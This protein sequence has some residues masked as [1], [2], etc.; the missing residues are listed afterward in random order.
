[1]A[2]VVGVE[3]VDV[4]AD[5]RH[6]A[7]HVGRPVA[8]AALA[9][10][11]HRVV[12]HARG[13]VGV[14]AA[15]RWEARPRAD[16]C[17]AGSCGAGCGRAGLPGCGLLRAP[18]RGLG[19]PPPG[20]PR[21]RETA[22]CRVPVAQPGCGATCAAARPGTS[23]AGAG[24]MSTGDHAAAAGTSRGRRR[25]P[26][27]RRDRLGAGAATA[28]GTVAEAASGAPHAASR[29]TAG[30]TVSSRRITLRHRRAELRCCTIWRGSSKL[31]TQHLRHA[32]GNAA[33]R[34]SGHVEP[35]RTTGGDR[36]LPARRSG[37]GVGHRRPMDP[38]AAQA[39]H[40]GAHGRGRRQAGRAR[41]RPGAGIPAPAVAPGA[42][43]GRSATPTSSSPTT[44]AR[45]R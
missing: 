40:A 32:S 3:A 8:R 27:R 33:H 26:S 4:V 7:G 37:R 21:R 5:D 12:R 22:A 17:G 31:V 25:R 23:R 20:W 43:R 28:A 11:V 35:V 16:G 45:C 42:G 34:S 39:R 36:L 2:V 29:K 24:P 10:D 13:V 6:R 38:R 15:R 14:A 1:M 19:L 41:P 44:S 30:T 9:V 18:A